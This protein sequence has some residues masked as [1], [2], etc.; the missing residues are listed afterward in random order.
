MTLIRKILIILLITISMG[1]FSLLIFQYFVPDDDSFMTFNKNKSFLL[2]TIITLTITPFIEEIVYRWGIV[3]NYKLNSFF[4]AATTFITALSFFEITKKTI[5]ILLLISIA[6]YIISL[7]LLRFIYIKYN[8]KENRIILIFSTISIIL[9]TFSHIENF[10][11]Y[12]D[13]VYSI[14]ICCIVLHGIIYTFVRLKY[15]LLFSIIT[16]YLYNIIDYIF[17]YY[18]LY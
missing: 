6:I 17:Y 9:F 10:K 15:G 16:H 4:I 8:P 11:L 12:D 13:L 2:K 1:I 5:I 14:L 7:R 18:S 3:F